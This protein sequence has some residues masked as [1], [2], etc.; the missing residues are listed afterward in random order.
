MSTSYVKKAAWIYIAA[1]LLFLVNFHADAA[2]SIAAKKLKPTETKTQKKG[3][4]KVTTVVMETSLGN[5]EIELNSEKAPKTTENFLKYVDS[6][7]YDGT[8]FHRIIDGFMVQGGGMKEDMSEKSTGEP[9]NNEADNGLKNEIGTLAMAR[10]NAPHSAT[11]QFFI[12]V[13]DNKFLNHTGKTDRGWGYAVFGKVTSGMDVVNKMK[14]VKTATK[15]FHENV[16]TSPI[17][18]KSVKRK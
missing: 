12:N 5:I 7:H 2:D 17:V 9:V 16:P 6:K 11:A 4:G 1:F 13:A 8:I 10:T 18:I 15:G 14:A 3:E